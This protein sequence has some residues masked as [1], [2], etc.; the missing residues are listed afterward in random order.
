MTI[1]VDQREPL[2]A[3]SIHDDGKGLDPVVASQSA[4]LRNMGERLAALGGEISVISPAGEGTTISGVIPANQLPGSD[5][6]H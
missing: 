6:A 1:S 4:G 5:Q 3:F 2:L